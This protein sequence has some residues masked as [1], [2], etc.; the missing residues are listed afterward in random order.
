VVTVEVL[1]EL[2]AAVLPEQVLPPTVQLLLVPVQLAGAQVAPAFR[3]QLP[4]VQV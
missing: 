3:L 1:P 4:S 2:S